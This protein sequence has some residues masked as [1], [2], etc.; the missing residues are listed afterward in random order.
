[1]SKIIKLHGSIVEAI[2]RSDPSDYDEEEYEEGE[3]ELLK[4][5]DPY[6]G[7]YV[8]GDTDTGS[9]DGGK[10]AMVDFVLDLYDSNDEHK[11]STIGGYYYQGGYQF[12]Y[13]P[14][15]YYEFEEFVETPLTKLNDFLIELAESE[16]K[17]DTKIKKITKYLKNI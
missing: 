1:M 6:H 11:G 15:T 10:S 12:D 17:F 8:L 9:Y 4:Q 14:D 5:N 3:L 7:W 2:F 13:G 16:Y